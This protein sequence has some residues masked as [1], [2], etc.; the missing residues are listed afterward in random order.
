MALLS[1][2]ANR[3]PVMAA[4]QMGVCRRTFYNIKATEEWRQLR[5][6]ITAAE[7]AYAFA[8]WHYYTFSKND[9]KRAHKL[10]QAFD[11]FGM[12]QHMRK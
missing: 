1:T 12:G 2:A 5:G 11:L 8:R 10:V 3:K 7:L 4:E 9:Y 6:P